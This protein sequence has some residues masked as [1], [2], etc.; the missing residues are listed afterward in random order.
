MSK[1]SGSM[2]Y[3]LANIYKYICPTSLLLISSCFAIIIEANSLW[4]STDLYPIYSTLI[5]EI[6]CNNHADDWSVHYVNEDFEELLARRYIDIGVF[7]IDYC[8]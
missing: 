1:I 5:V 2:N 6:L 3:I 4:F 7:V 8:Q